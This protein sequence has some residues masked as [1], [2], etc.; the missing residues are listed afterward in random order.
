VLTLQGLPPPY[1]GAGMSPPHQREPSST[2]LHSMLTCN[3][4][5]LAKVTEGQNAGSDVRGG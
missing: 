1:I 2:K 3:R 5:Q 4:K